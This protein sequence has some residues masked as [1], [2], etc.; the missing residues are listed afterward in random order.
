[1]GRIFAY[2]GCFSFVETSSL[3]PIDGNI[4][5][6]F[7]IVVSNNPKFT[8]VQMDDELLC[9]CLLS[10]ILALM[11]QWEDISGVT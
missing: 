3:E 6:R 5:L 1:M 10:I 7:L 8:V 9:K 4:S 11:G 2:L